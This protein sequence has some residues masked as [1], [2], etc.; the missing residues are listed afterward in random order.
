MKQNEKKTLRIGLLGFGAMGKTHTW[1]V[2]NLPF[3]YGALPFSAEVV[4]VC[5]TSQEKSEHVAN[6]FGMKLCYHN[7][8]FEFE[9]I[10]GE[11]VIDVLFG[12]YVAQA[13]VQISFFFYLFYR[14]CSVK[15]LRLF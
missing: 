5:T 2:Q 13:P 14:I 15:N 1:A 9:K 12:C 6:E 4:G 3:F 8:D 11:Y 7:H 10:N